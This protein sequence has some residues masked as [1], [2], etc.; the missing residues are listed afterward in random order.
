MAQHWRGSKGSKAC[1][2]TKLGGRFRRWRL[3][4]IC[5]AACRLL[6]AWALRPA[7]GSGRGFMDVWH[8]E[9]GQ[10]GE[11]VWVEVQACE[12]AQMRWTAAGLW[13]MDKPGWGKRAGFV[14]GD[15][16][17]HDGG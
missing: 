9:L 12:W 11:M 17:Q 16:G 8:D 6:G 4:A 2:A 3:G 1:G 7:P 10:A 5:S 15:T 13:I 14:H